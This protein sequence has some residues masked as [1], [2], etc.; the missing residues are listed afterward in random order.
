MS[1]MPCDLENADAASIVFRDDT[2][3][4]EAAAGYDVPGWFILRLRRHAEGWSEPTAEELAGFGPISQRLVAA[5]TEATDSTGAYF[6]SFGENYPHFHFL[7]T[8]R[9]AD[10]AP[11]NK[12]ANILGLRAELSDREAALRFA[13]DVRAAFERQSAT[14]SAAG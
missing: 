6:M 3:S 10:L 9:P 5:I 2:W 12:S 4:C 7:V 14:Q 1:C 13:A 11:E 8:A